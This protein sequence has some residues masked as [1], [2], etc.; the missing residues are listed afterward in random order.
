MNSLN[1]R[2]EKYIQSLP[3][4]ARMPSFPEWWST[5]SDMLKKRL[6]V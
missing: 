4:G 3:Y 6:A 2:Y 1:E 5:P